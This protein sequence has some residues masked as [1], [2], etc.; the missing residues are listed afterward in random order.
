MNSLERLRPTCFKCKKKVEIFECMTEYATNKKKFIARC[1]GETEFAELS[2]MT[3]LFA[4]IGS[5]YA[6]MPNEEPYR[7][8]YD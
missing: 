6:F 5:A 1:H 2:E 3:I 8:S 7:I 4:Q